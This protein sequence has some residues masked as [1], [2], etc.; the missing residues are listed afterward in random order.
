MRG[1]RLKRIPILDLIMSHIQPISTNSIG[2]NDRSS[3]RSGRRDGLRRRDTASEFGWG[4]RKLSAHGTQRLFVRL[5]VQA[6][7]V[8]IRR[9]V[10]LIGRRLLLAITDLIRD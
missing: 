6:V 5:S 3:K 8:E 9:F 1:N 4:R 7:E 10:P 2:R